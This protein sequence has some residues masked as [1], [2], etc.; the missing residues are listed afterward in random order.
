MKLSELPAVGTYYYLCTPYSRYKDGLE[1]AW[2]AACLAAAALVRA[3]VPFYCP[4]AETHPIA[5]IGD[6]DPMDHEIWLACDKPKLD[7]AGG[8]LVCMMPGWSDSYGISVEIE[9]FQDAGK[10]I[11]YLTWPEMEVATDAERDDSG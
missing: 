1:A 2:Q 9:A 5:V 6:L 4:I 11:Y 8:L 10:P 3:K 7:A